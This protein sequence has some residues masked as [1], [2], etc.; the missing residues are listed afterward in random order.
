VD[1]CCIAI[2]FSIPLVWFWKLWKRRGKLNPKQ[3]GTGGSAV[4]SIDALRSHQQ[5]D[6]DLAPYAFL[7]SA[8]RPRYYYFECVEVFRRIVFIGVLPLLTTKASRRAAFGI[9]FSLISLAM[10][11]ELEPFRARSNNVLVYVAQYAILLTYGAALAIETDLS[12][13]VDDP[14]KK[15][16][17]KGGGLL[18][19]VLV[20][21]NGTILGLAFW[22]SMVRFF[23]CFLPCCLP[24][25]IILL[26]SMNNVLPGASPPH[27]QGG[28]CAGR[29]AAPSDDAGAGHCRGGHG[30]CLRPRRL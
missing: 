28:G 6:A 24:T 11:R 19:C 12:N 4:L 20:L 23:F 16:F 8:Y 21:V 25:A 26:S 30:L 22:M 5:E 15:G 17:V 13:G 7:Y 29:V 14:T 9:F 10:Y 3:L 27:S 2:Y 1:A 18:G